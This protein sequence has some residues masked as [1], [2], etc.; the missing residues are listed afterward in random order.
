[1]SNTHRCWL[2]RRP[3]P[4]NAHVKTRLAIALVSMV[5][6]ACAATTA[7]ERVVLERVRDGGLQPQAI[8]DSQGV[9]HIVYLKGDAWHA[10]VYYVRRAIDGTYS[11]PARVND[12]K[13]SAIAIA[14]VRGA[15]LALGRNGRVHVVWNG[16]SQPGRLWYSRQNDGHDT[17]EPQRDLIT[18][19]TGLDGGGT[20]A[21]DGSGRVFVAWRGNPAGRSDAAGGVFVSDSNDDGRTFSRERRVD[22]GDLGA[23][24]CCAMRAG[25]DRQGAVYLLYRAATRDIDRDA[26]LLSST[27]GGKTFSSTTA[28]RWRLQSCPLSTA[29]LTR[30][31]S[32]MMAAWETAGQV[33][34]G[35]IV[36]GAVASRTAAPGRGRRKHPVMAF[37]ATGAMLFAWLEG[38][39]WQRGGSVAWQVYDAQGRP[40]SDRGIE[41]GVPVWGLAAAATLPDG[42]FLLLY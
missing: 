33:T 12:R 21:A 31:P 6:P 10:D 25:V 9:T 32:G 34:F 15:Q 37:N 1:M 3:L 19:G 4:C 36:S 40:T 7:N 35:P 17:F 14:S 16:S 41:P 27:D 39:A 30:G 18:W 22:S 5:L 26:V 11:R 13:G 20:I 28:D 8:T 23:C 29:F 2:T 38:T 42:R 24:A